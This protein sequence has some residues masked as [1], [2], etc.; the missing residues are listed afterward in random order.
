VLIEIGSGRDTGQP[1]LIKCGLADLAR[2]PER[3]GRQ[4]DGKL[5]HISIIPTMHN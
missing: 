1:D 3:D 4:R 2:Q 5:W